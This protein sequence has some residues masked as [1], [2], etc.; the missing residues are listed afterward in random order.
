MSGLLHLDAELVQADRR[1][2]CEA[3]DHAHHAADDD[4]CRR[5]AVRVVGRVGERRVVDGRDGEADAE[6]R[7]GEHERRDDDAAERVAP[8]R[9]HREDRG[10]GHDETGSG[11]EGRPH[12][13]QQ[14]PAEERPD[15][16]G[17]EKAQQDERGR[18]L[19]VRQRQSREDRDLDDDRDEC[20]ADE[21]RHQ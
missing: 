9:T 3:D 14:E 21:E 20:R 4:E 8:P 6:A 16:H 5:H 12:A 2:Q 19:R 18:R 1:Q 10:P 11:D 15:G 7:D 17:D 13:A